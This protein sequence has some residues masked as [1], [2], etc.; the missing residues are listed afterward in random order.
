MLVQIYEVTT[1]EEARA[2][3]EAGVD[4]VGVLVGAGEF[5]RELPAAAAQQVA[6]GIRSGAKF[7]ALFLTADLALIA[8]WAEALRPDILHLGAAPELLSPAQTAMLKGRLPGIAMSGGVQVAELDGQLLNGF[9]IHSFQK[10]AHRGHVETGQQQGGL[11]FPC[12]HV[13][14]LLLFNPTEE[15]L[16]DLLRIVSQSVRDLSLQDERL[17]G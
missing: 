17:I 6:A 16:S 11:L 1:P 9:G 3:S 4:H 2:V 15:H 8:A 10:L 5:P 12:Q 7:S 13:R 14:L